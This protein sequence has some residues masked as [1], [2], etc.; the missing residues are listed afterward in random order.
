MIVYVTNNN[1]EPSRFTPNSNEKQNY[2][3]FSQTKLI[4]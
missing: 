2:Q 4:N 3:T 1:K